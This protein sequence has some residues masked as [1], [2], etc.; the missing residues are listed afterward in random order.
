[1]QL[2]LTLNGSV[3]PF[4]NYLE[5]F[6]KIRSSLLI[7]IDT[8]EKAFVA[9][10]YTEDRSS[11]RFSAI[12]F[13]DC[14]MS[15]V[16]NDGE[17]ELGTNRIKAGIFMQ[18]AKLIKIV[19]TFGTNVDDNGNSVFEINFDYDKLYNP[20]GTVDF[21]ATTISFVT[22]KL[23]MK[24]DGFRMSEFNYLSDEV[25]NNKV[26]NVQDPV[27]FT[28][29]PSVLSAIINTSDIVKIDPRKD[30]LTFYVE[31]KKV[32]VKDYT[33]MSDPN[34]EW[35]ANFIYQIGTLDVDPGYKIKLNIFRKKFIDMM[36]K[37][38]ETYNVILGRRVLPEDGSYVVDR[39]LFD[40]V[41]SHTKV[42]ISMINEC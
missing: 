4:I 25:F 3:K 40:S 38:D 1:M 28:L 21:V 34:K 42:V 13:E 31:D 20:K 24:M 23:K 15:I 37:A 32:Y 22:E 19:K 2:K 30:A 9:K 27:K 6:E 39:I 12:S 16:S 36:N 14:N 10:T 26:F 29:T 5:N 11:V 18:L 17:N 33:A 35:S 41:D 8:T 7:E